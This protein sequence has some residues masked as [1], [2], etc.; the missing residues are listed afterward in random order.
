MKLKSVLFNMLRLSEVGSPGKLLVRDH[1][2]ECHKV[3][4]KI[5]RLEIST[6]Q[7]K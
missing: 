4:K 7:V 5:P 2:Q 1:D 3:H 6:E